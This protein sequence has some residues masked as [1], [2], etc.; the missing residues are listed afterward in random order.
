MSKISIIFFVVAIFLVACGADTKTHEGSGSFSELMTNSGA[1][2]DFG[3]LI[4]SAVAGIRYKSGTHYGVTGSDGKYGYQNGK[5]VEFFIG[6]ISLGLV[7]EPVPRVTPYELAGGN[8]GKA[9]K[10]ARFLQTLDNDDNAENGIVINDVIHSLAENASLNFE[11]P[12]WKEISS[13]EISIED[14]ISSDVNLLVFELTAATEAG[15]RYLKPGLSAFSH[16]SSTLSREVDSLESK[17]RG[18]VNFSKCAI[19]SDC[20][21]LDLSSASLSRCASETEALVY[22]DASVNSD[23][24]D[25]LMKDRSQL[26]KI[27]E[28]IGSQVKPRLFESGSCQISQVPKAAICNQ[29]GFCEVGSS[30]DTLPDQGDDASNR[31]A[32]S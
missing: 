6:G 19:D 18:L 23:E 4:D 13:G 25:S 32:G 8:P 29:A 3:Y 14:S 28:E 15:S 16:L 2:D 24:L 9:L 11:S 26:I 1:P 12:G 31:P 5:P 27:R 10:I 7:E 17:T 22:S 20:K 21:L 30:F